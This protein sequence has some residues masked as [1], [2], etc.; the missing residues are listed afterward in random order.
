[1][2][3]MTRMMLMMMMMLLMTMIM[4][5]FS[6]AILMIDFRFL[7]FCTIDKYHKLMSQYTTRAKKR[8]TI[9]QMVKSKICAVSK[10][11]KKACEMVTA[12][13]Y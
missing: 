4:K 9:S 1:M 3:M 6:L 11:A 12:M 13:C 7:L 5:N 8:R 2:M 10:V